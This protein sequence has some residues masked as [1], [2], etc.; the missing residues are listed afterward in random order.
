M[1]RTRLL[2]LIAILAVAGG[3]D[4]RPRHEKS[5][6]AQRDNQPGQ[7]DYYALALSWSPAFCATHSDPN[8]CATGRQLGFVLHGLWPQ[9]AKGYPADCSTQP[10]PEQDRAKYAPLYPSPTLI[11]HEWSKHGTCSGLAPAAYFEL[12]A[13]LKGQTV[14]PAPYLRPAEPIRVS[15]ADFIG[16]FMKANP[17]M[18]AGAVLPFCTSGGRFLSEIHACFDKDG[19]ADSC[20]PSESK[21]SDKSCGQA[22]FLIQSVR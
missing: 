22:N 19:K 6:A 12:S 3:A 2:F 18:P 21:R 14:I 1:H 10:L 15:N 20:A 5:N 9:Y 16:A 7:F 4:A 8:Q 11:K 13:K 17:A